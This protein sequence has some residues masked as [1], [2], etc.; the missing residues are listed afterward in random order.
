ML[1]VQATITANHCNVPNPVTSASLYHQA[2]EQK[3]ISISLTSR[4]FKF[5]VMDTFLWTLPKVI[6]TLSSFANCIIEDL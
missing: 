6:G 4:E 5:S 1:Q 2:S 3:E